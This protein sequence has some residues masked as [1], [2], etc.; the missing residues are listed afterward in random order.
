MKVV[1]ITKSLAKLLVFYH[2]NRRTVWGSPLHNDVAKNSIYSAVK[3]ENMRVCIYIY[4]YIHIALKM[5]EVILLPYLGKCLLKYC[6]QLWAL[7]FKKRSC[8]PWTLST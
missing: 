4:I 1:P 7:L 8:F 2:Q 6:I 5:S 3:C